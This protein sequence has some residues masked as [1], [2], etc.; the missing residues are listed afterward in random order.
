MTGKW[1]KRLIIKVVCN[2][3]YQSNKLIK[4]S[5]QLCGKDKKNYIFDEMKNS[6]ILVVSSSQCVKAN[7]NMA[8]AASLAICCPRLVYQQSM[9]VFFLVVLC[10]C[11]CVCLL[12]G[13]D[14]AESV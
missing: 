13:M 4:Q 12:W 10:V 1:L 14:S 8:C 3:F 7:Q 11:V 9:Y 5:F 2:Y 6:L